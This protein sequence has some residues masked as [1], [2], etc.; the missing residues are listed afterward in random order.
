MTRKLLVLP[1]LFGVATLAACSQSAV[2]TDARLSN[3]GAASVAQGASD[4]V[5]RFIANDTETEQLTMQNPEHS[6][7]QTAGLTP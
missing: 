7:E 3:S 5:G 4:S 2:R 6:N 1:V